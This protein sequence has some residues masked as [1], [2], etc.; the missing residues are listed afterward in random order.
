MAPFLSYSF[1]RRFLMGDFIG[2]GCS[3]PPS[4]ALYWKTR[5]TISRPFPLYF[6]PSF[7]LYHSEVCGRHFFL[8]KSACL[9]LRSSKEEGWAFFFSGGLRLLAILVSLFFPLSQAFFHRTAR[10]H[11]ALS[12]SPRP[13][14]FVGVCF[15]FFLWFVWLRPI[16]YSFC[17]CIQRGPFF[18]RSARL[19]QTRPLLL[20]L[21]LG[22]RRVSLLFFFVYPIPPMET[23]RTSSRCLVFFAS[24]QASF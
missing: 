9:P 1:R 8:P 13:F 7:F 23:P 19:S 15:F 5:V 22:H 18:P 24:D 20:H 16:F 6:P 14:F 3:S 12:F 11:G 10:H 17:R 4:Q 21:V 2:C